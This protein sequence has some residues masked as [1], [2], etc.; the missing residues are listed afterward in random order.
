MKKDEKDVLFTQTKEQI[1][2]L[3]NKQLITKEQADYLLIKARE[4]L[5]LPHLK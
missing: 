1:L 3:L 5:G 4:K 2:S